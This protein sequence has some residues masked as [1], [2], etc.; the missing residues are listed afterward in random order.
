MTEEIMKK[1]QDIQSHLQKK[2]LLHEEIQSI[3]KETNDRKIRI[4]F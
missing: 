3:K 2:M 4:A 1:Y